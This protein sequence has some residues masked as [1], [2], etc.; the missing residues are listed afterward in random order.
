M[1]KTCKVTTNSF[2]AN[3]G[4]NCT[5]MAWELSD[6]GVVGWLQIDRSDLLSAAFLTPIQIWAGESVKKLSALGPIFALH[7]LSPTGS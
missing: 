2:L 5:S 7:H 1:S 6:L 4:D 3:G